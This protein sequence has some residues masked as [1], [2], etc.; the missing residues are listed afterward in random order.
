MNA[1]F[2]AALAVHITC[3]FVCTLLGLVP[4]LTRKGGRNHRRSG[5]LFAYLMGV[6][7]GA[8][9]IMT[10]L[11]FSLYFLALSAMATLGLF[12]G[13]RVLRRKRPDITPADRATALDWTATVCIVGISAWTLYASLSGGTGGGSTVSLALAASG[14]TYGGYDI[15]RFCA[16]SA[17]PFTPKLWLYEHLVKMIGAYSAVMSAFSG[18]F[19]RFIPAPWSQLWPSIVFQLLA[20]AWIIILVMQDRARN[21]TA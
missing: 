20:I 2:Y 5:R 12:S 3:G 21:R 7:L 15:W 6:L 1:I 11:H 14:L 9:W 19:I 17:W 4:L 16:P 18:N 8:A 10:A 13:V